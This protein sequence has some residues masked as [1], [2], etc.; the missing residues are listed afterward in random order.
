MSCLIPLHCQNGQNVCITVPQ[1]FN[2]TT[3]GFGVATV[4][5]TVSV[6]SVE[7]F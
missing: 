3:D 2:D 6:S 7:T 5:K 1:D 4:P